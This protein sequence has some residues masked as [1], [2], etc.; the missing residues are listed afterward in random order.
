MAAQKFDYQKLAI[1]SAIGLAAYYFLPTVLAMVES[2]FS[3]LSAALSTSTTS[4]TAADSDVATVD[5]GTS[6]S[7]D[8]SASTDG[9]QAESPTGSDAGGSTVTP[10]RLPVRH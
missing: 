8:S 10:Q 2:V 9:S 3:S 4:T 6:V 1:Y 5:S 7:G